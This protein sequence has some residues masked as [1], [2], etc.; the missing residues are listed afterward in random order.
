MNTSLVGGR[1]RILIITRLRITFSV[2]RYMDGDELRTLQNY[3]SSNGVSQFKGGSH[4]LFGL[5]HLQ[6]S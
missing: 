6:I 5:C 2:G 1:T 3:R 4:L